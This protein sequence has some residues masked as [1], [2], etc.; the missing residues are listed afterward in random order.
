MINN[1]HR[2]DSLNR[3]KL[4]AEEDWWAVWFGFFLLTVTAAGIIYNIPEIGKW[5][6]SPLEIVTGSLLINILLLM[7]GTGILLTVGIYTMG[8]ANI[9]QYV[10]GFTFIFILSVASYILAGQE[11]IRQYGF[12]YAL[13]ALITGLVITNT[14][15]TPKWL[16]TGAR[17][18]LYIKIGLV[19]LG[20]EILFN[21]ILQLGTPGLII[22][23]GVTPVVII[24]MYI[25][26]TKFLKMRSKSLA[27][28]I[29]AATSVCGV[30]AAIAAA[31]ASRAKREELSLAVGMTMVFTVAMMVGMPAIARFM[32][33]NDHVGGAW[34][35]GTIDST[36]AVVAAGAMLGETAEKV[37]AI[38]KLIQ[39]VLIGFI[40][41]AIALYWVSRVER[42]GT[43]KPDAME[44]W[45]RFPKFILGFV[46]A[47]LIFSFVLMPLLGELTVTSILDDTKTLRGWFFCMAFVSI[48]L[49]SNFRELSK[50][51]A[52]GKPFILYI[53]GQTMNILLT[54]LIAWIVFSLVW[55]F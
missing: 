11:T 4:I 38:V 12:G 48:G 32:G 35:G 42:T 45:N 50:Q 27:I 7:T 55:T 47:S 6:N 41:F 1:K 44:I 40:A 21:H 52:G 51:L 34:L 8:A 23:W 13:W 15:R 22:A 39:N 28:V 29:A 2:S 19:L 36:G 10:C 17:S 33:L 18:E 37:A 20:A 14:I 24:L 26:G 25:F 16:L 9:R 30:S 31:A 43:E 54:L 49:E 53:T 3:S 46:M 5:V